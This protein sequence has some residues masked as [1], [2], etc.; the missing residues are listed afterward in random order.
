MNL[1]NSILSL[2]EALAHG[3]DADIDAWLEV[4]D[5]LTFRLALNYLINEREHCTRESCI[6]A[7]DSLANPFDIEFAT[8]GDRCKGHG[9]SMGQELSRL[10]CRKAKIPQE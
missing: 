9:F 3:S 1:N 5:A 7:V 8:S 6:R 10:A 2:K 4:T